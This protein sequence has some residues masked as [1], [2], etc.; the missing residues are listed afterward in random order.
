LIHLC[1]V[2]GSNTSGSTHNFLPTALK[3]LT[4]HRDYLAIPTDFYHPK[5]VQDRATND[6]DD[7]S[8]WNGHYDSLF[9]AGI[10]GWSWCHQTKTLA[11]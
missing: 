1:E 5:I 10:N 2:T 3:I 9:A 4:K 6:F 11:G 7:C 8:G